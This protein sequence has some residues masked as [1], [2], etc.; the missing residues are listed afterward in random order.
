MVSVDYLVSATCNTAKR[1]SHSHSP[2]RK[3]KLPGKW[4]EF[5]S[6]HPSANPSSVRISRN[7]AE[8]AALRR[9]L[10]C[11]G[12]PRNCRQSVCLLLLN[13][14]SSRVRGKSAL[15]GRCD[16]APQDKDDARRTRRTEDGKGD[17][18]D[19]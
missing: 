4:S 14:N 11:R 3:R 5:P 1:A 8:V 9:R 16:P 7:L 10:S 19:G 15:L 6:L 12:S 2:E 17:F 18:A 13:N